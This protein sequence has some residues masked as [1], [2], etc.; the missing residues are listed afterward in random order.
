MHGPESYAAFNVE[1]R[2]LQ[3]F[4]TVDIANDFST[5]AKPI[6]GVDL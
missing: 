2:I 3:V 5:M 6:H 4:V 1:L